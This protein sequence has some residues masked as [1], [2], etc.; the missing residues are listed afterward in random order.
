MLRAG[1]IALASV[2]L[3]ACAEEDVMKEIDRKIA[4]R[5]KAAE[6]AVAE[7]QAYLAKN[8]ARAEVKTT[9]S[10]LQY[11]VVRAVAEDLPK[12][13]PTDRVLVHYEG[14]LIDG[15]VFDSSYARNEPIAF[16]LSEVI[17]GWT[18]GLQ[19]MK[20][21]EEFILTLPSDI[22]YGPQGAGADIPPNATLVFKVELLGFDRP[23]GTSVKAK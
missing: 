10:G 4:E 5:A 17:P 6:S 3:A 2:T 11:E 21:G 1:L 7:G 22:G 23:D 20:P 14:K 16:V 18:E 15:T 8:A 12:P 9:P 19:L 13:T